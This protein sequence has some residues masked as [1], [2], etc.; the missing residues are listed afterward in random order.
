M[1]QIFLRRILKV[2]ISNVED[3]YKDFTRCYNSIRTK[4]TINTPNELSEAYF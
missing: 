3:K 1:V 4:T 2:K